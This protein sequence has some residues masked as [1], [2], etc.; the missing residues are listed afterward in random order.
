MN[1][2]RI[3]TAADAEVVGRLPQIVNPIFP[4]TRTSRKMVGTYF[5]QKSDED[6]EVPTASI[7]KKAKMTDFMWADFLSL[8]RV[9]SKK[10]N[11]I[12]AN[13][14]YDGVEFIQT[15]LSSKLGDLPFWIINPFAPAFHMLD[16]QKSKFA[17]VDMI[18][19]VP[20]KD[21]YFSTA[22]ELKV[23]FDEELNKALTKGRNHKPLI[24]THLEFRRDVNLDFFFIRGTVTDA[25]GYFVSERLKY[26]I[27]EAECTGIIFTD[28]NAHYG[29]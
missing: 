22:A 24:I 9:V 16:M 10:L 27:E 2:Y 23:A 20:V 14:I 13:H 7:H 29:F 21:E 1:Y 4:T 12:L 28:I 5:F 17:L 15:S 25:L 3:F 18:S 8:Q 6:V 11:D 26:E 19:M